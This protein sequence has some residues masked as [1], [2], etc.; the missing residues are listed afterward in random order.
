MAA[1]PA[2]RGTAFATLMVARSAALVLVLA[3]AA[4]CVRRQLTIRT[5]PPGAQ[6]FVNDQLKGQSPVTYDFTWYGWHR[7]TLRKDGYARLDDR[8]K[9]KAPVY[10][11]VPFDLVMELMPFAVRDTHTWDYQLAAAQALEPPGPPA[12]EPEFADPNAP[13]PPKAEEA[14]APATEDPDAPR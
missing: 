6:V 12:E 4:G 5:D 3:P 11:W 8:R 9:L 10:L 14:P 1:R 2:V 7:I 13:P